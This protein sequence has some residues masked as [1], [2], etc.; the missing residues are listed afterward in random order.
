M[1]SLVCHSLTLSE[2]VERP[3]HLSGS[4]SLSCLISSW[5]PLNSCFGFHFDVFQK[6]SKDSPAYS[7]V[8]KLNYE[9]LLWLLNLETTL[10]IVQ[11]AFESPFNLYESLWTFM[12][13]CGPLWT[14]LNH[15]KVRMETRKF[16]CVC[17]GVDRSLNG[18]IL[19]ADRLRSSKAVEQSISVRT[20]PTECSGCSVMSQVL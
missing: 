19:S 7:P 13:L 10:R 17:I 6:H 16:E 3:L 1:L 12:R 11:F 14:L 9:P 18:R 2:P 15:W 20:Q 8:H 4:L 5:R